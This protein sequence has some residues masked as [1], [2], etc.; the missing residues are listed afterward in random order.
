MTNKNK[1]QTEVEIVIKHQHIIVQQT[2]NINF[3]L[4]D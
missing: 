2:I 4:I 3:K 1:F